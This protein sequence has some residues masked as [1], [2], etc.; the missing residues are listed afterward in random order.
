MNKK[1]TKINTILAAVITIG[2][3]ISVILLGI[4]GVLKNKGDNSLVLKILI[5]FFVISTTAIG[6]AGGIY[7]II[8][9]ITN[10]EEV[11]NQNV[12]DEDEGAVEDEQEDK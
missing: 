6:I 4:W 8:S 12:K 10:N 1:K 9:A 3:L 5:V 7:S 2:V 11:I